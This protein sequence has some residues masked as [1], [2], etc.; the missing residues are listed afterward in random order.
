M[1]NKYY[2]HPLGPTGRGRGRTLQARLRSVGLGFM[3]GTI[4]V[5]GV[6]VL[7]NTA[8]S[9][10]KAY[11]NEFIVLCISAAAILLPG[12]SGSLLKTDY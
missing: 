12:M 2:G 5:I 4:C 10:V 11:K 6:R 3:V 7:S 9:L 1:S 8:A